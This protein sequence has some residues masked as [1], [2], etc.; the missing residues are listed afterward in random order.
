[1]FSKKQDSSKEKL[2]NTT[3]SKKLLADMYINQMKINKLKR[4]GHS[5]RLC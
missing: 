4:I 3:E 1:M 2:I 5:Q